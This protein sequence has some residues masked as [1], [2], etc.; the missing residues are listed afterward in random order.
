MATKTNNVT[1]NYDDKRFTEVNNDK[2]QALP[3][4]ENVYG[5]RAEEADK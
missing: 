1:V 4:L 2:Q 5:G 3:D